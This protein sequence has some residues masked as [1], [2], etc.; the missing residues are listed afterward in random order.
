MEMNVAISMDM[1]RF[2]SS[3]YWERKRRERKVSFIIHFFIITPLCMYIYTYTCV[4][5][6]EN[7]EK[8]MYMCKICKPTKLLTWRR[9]G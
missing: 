4:S 8:N 9:V 6:D 1:K 5:S 2:L 7:L 3:I